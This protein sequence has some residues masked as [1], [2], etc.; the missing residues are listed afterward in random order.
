MTLATDGK[1]ENNYY[2]WYAISPNPMGLTHL[3][4]DKLTG[5]WRIVHATGYWCPAICSIDVVK[6]IVLLQV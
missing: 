2:A 6:G 4:C 5:K 3:R 1:T